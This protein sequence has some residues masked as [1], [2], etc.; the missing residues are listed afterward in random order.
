MLLTLFLSIPL[1]DLA[2]TNKKSASQKEKKIPLTESTKISH[3]NFQVLPTT[4][5]TASVEKGSNNNSSTAS[6]LPA[7]STTTSTTAKEIDSENGKLNELKNKNLTADDFKLVFIS[8]DSSKDNSEL[9]SSSEINPAGPQQ[10]KNNNNNNKISEKNLVINNNHEDMEW[11]DCMAASSPKLV[12]KKLPIGSPSPPKLPPKS[13][14]HQFYTLDE[15]P[16]DFDFNMPNKTGHNS[17]IYL[18][19]N[20]P[21]LIS[22]SN[23]IRTAAT[24]DRNSPFR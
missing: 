1:T 13:K 8:S 2:L 17:P 10:D 23:T 20:S 14:L 11:S 9:N 4:A 12:K 24:R 7:S 18:V 16:D 19:P 3:Q 21:S 15:L 5:A 22:S 6:V